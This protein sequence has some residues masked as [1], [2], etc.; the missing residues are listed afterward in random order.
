MTAATTMQACTS[1]GSA[2]ARQPPLVT[3]CGRGGI[4][5]AGSLFDGRLRDETDL[6]RAGTLQQRHR[7]NDFTVGDAIVAAN[8]DRRVR[9]ASQHRGSL[10][11]DFAGIERFVL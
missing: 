11:L 7:G 9:R 8:E 2:M 5:S 10:R 4:R 3:V 1:T 6:A